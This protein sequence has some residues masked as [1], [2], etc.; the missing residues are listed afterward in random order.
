MNE[1]IG[2]C[3]LSC[4]EC[5][6]YQATQKDDDEERKRVAEMWTKEYGADVKPEDINCDGCTVFDGRHFQ[7]CSVCEIWKCGI[8]RGAENCA[9]CADYA[10]EKLGKFFEMVPQAKTKLDE[11]RSSLSG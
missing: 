6:A 7:H 2:V 11:I 3:G 5:P 10:C 4:S 8:D 1:I 9:H